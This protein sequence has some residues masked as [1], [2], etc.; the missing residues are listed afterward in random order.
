MHFSHRAL[1]PP[2]HHHNGR[3]LRVTHDIPHM[4]T[5]PI[6]STHA[7]A[8][9]TRRRR[10]ARWLTARAAWLIADI[11]AILTCL[12]LFAHVLP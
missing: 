11:V 1:I 10:L 9:T 3:W 5:P 8:R 4:A 7:P 12:A 2:N 6:S